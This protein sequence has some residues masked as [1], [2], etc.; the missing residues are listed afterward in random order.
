MVIVVVIVAVI[1]SSEIASAACAQFLFCLAGFRV[2]KA[3]RWIVGLFSGQK[4]TMELF[5]L[6]YPV[7]HIYAYCPFATVC[8][9]THLPD[10]HLAI[11]SYI[12]AGSSP[13]ATLHFFRPSLAFTFNILFLASHVKVQPVLLVSTLVTS[14]GSAGGGM[15][16]SLDSFLA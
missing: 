12:V 3:R 7:L 9:F 16:S 15:S 1:A 10:P 11:I 5:A 6:I 14:F 4:W 2:I 13:T 8:V